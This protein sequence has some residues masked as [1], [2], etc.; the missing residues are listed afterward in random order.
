MVTER[1]TDELEAAAWQ[2][3]AEATLYCHGKPIGVVAACDPGSQPA[4]YDQCFM[5]DF[6]VSGLVFLMHGQAEIVRNFLSET[7]ALQ[8]YQKHMDCF[9]PGQG[10]MPASFQVVRRN[11]QEWLQPDFGEAAIAKV[12]PVDSCFW[13]LFL[14]RSYVKAT[15]DWAL[16]HQPGFQA[17]I[18][19]ILDLC[20]TA[21]FEMLPTLLV[22]DGSFTI[23]RRMGVYGH[24]IDIQALFYIALRSARELLERSP[25]NEGYREAAER[26]IQHLAYHI[27]EYYWLNLDRLNAI[28]RYNVEEYGKTAVNR[29]NINPATIPQWLVEWLPDEGGYFA[30]NLG[31]GRLDYRF[32]SQG[33]LMAILAS[34]ADAIQSQTIMATLEYSWDSL[35]GEMPMK[36]CFPALEGQDWR[37]LTGS[38]PKNAPWSY[39]NGGNWP[40]L[41][42][43]LT[44]AAQKV[45]RR[46]LAERALAIACQRLLDDG[47]P[48]Y[49]DGRNGRLIG[50]E[51][52]RYQ[53]WTVAGFLGAQALL[54]NPDCPDL[55]SFEEEPVVIACSV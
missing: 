36:L 23:D 33:N 25:Q 42:W 10:L 41:L 2:L 50:K 21:R 39:H 31:P 37:T 9:Q 5:R 7:L 53:I 32:F 45:G 4:N 6:A 24:P 22:P 26:R 34:L 55:V 29:F 46:E 30:G 28:Y 16:V 17:G 19:A 52:R 20:L 3:L 11:G 48:E 38:D 51:A 18:R 27:R 43:L 47:W 14:L 13:W 44:A 1:R 49:Y 15:G 12:A 35:I 8:N 54:N 40:F